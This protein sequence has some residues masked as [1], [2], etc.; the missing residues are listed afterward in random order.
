MKP[1]LAH[2]LK[3][4]GY[5]QLIITSYSGLYRYNMKDIVYV[6]EINN[7]IPR[8]FVCEFTDASISRI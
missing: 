6:A 8:L 3:Q 4:G 5:Y 2:E 1:L 7:Q